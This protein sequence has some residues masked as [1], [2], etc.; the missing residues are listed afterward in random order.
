L[1]RPQTQPLSFMPPQSAEVDVSTDA[2]QH[3]SNLHYQPPSTTHHERNELATRDQPTATQNFG[4]DGNLVAES[5]GLPATRLIAQDALHNLELSSASPLPSEAIPVA[6]G[7]SMQF[8]QSEETNRAEMSMVFYPCNQ[9]HVCRVANY[10]CAS[11]DPRCR[12][13]P[14][15]GW[16][17]Y[18]QHP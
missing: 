15:I 9:P 10:S 1:G 11:V 2:R 7:P 17:I 6:A 12:R 18:L 8:D 16:Q 14:A 13:G 3:K 5:S 4:S